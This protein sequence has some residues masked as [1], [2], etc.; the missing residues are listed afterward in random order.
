MNNVL[1]EADPSWYCSN[2]CHQYW[3]ADCVI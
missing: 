2:F 3:Q 1:W